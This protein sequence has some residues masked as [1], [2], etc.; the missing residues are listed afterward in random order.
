MRLEF[1]TRRPGLLVGLHA[2]AFWPVWRWYAGRI[3]DGG[4]ES[5]ALVALAAAVF[6]SWP[7]R[8]LRLNLRDPLLNSAVVLTLVYAI[9]APFA[10]PLPRAL[11]AM[12]ALAATWTSLAEA[13]ARLWP[14][15][16]LLL[17]S[18]PVIESLQFYAGYPL[19]LLTATG[20]T[21]LLD[22]AGLD[23]SRIGTNMSLGSQL[24]L[25]DAPC[26]GVRMLWTAAVL[27]CV[28]TAQRARVGFG[29]LA[30]A[31]LFAVP[32]VL[33]AN[34]VRAALLFLLETS[35]E[36]PN[37]FWHAAVGVVSFTLVALLLYAS[38]RAQL[39]WRAA[40]RAPRI[41]VAS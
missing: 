24:V 41:A 2:L 13:R 23:V 20:A 25:V 32:V 27:V 9:L 10:P 19:R 22:L 31:A 33:V 4:D 18:V 6:V 12:S 30:L 5:W 1:L 38:E 36:P 14:V 7:A 17:L 29:A 15:L 16:G 28:L 40:P 39:R 8:G 35:A 26:S 37:A 21:A 3:D 34:S 11:I